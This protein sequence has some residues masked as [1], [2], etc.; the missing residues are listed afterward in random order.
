MITPTKPASYKVGDWLEVVKHDGLY[1]VQIERIIWKEKG[2][3]SS[4]FIWYE[5]DEV[6]NAA[7]E[8]CIFLFNNGTWSEGIPYGTVV[9]TNQQ[10]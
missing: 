7:A 4:A 9:V 2:T 5:K 3:K 10:P 1:E 8:W 6:L